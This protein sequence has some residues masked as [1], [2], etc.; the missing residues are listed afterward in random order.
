MKR[1]STVL[2]AALA[3]VEFSF[4]LNK[5]MSYTSLT[6]IPS[7]RPLFPNSTMPQQSVTDVSSLERETFHST[8]TDGPRFQPRSSTMA[9]HN[10]LSIILAAKKTHSLPA[11]S[12][13]GVSTS[14]MDVATRN[15]R[16]KSSEPEGAKSSSKAGPYMTT[17]SNQDS[18]SRRN[19]QSSGSLESTIRTPAR[20][21]AEPTSTSSLV[22]AFLH[23]TSST[24]EATSTFSALATRTKITIKLAQSSVTAAFDASFTQPYSVSFRGSTI[25]YTRATFS[26]LA[27]ITAATTITTPSWSPTTMTVNLL[28]LRVSSLLVLAEPGKCATSL[29]FARLWLPGSRFEGLKCPSL[30]AASQEHRKPDVSFSIPHH[31]DMIARWNGGIGGLNL[32]G[33]PCMWPFCPQR[34]HDDKSGNDQSDDEDE[35]EQ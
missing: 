35:G 12:P 30:L 21:S 6:T 25:Y 8:S 20:K 4:G 19:W 26:D 5:S 22:W 10:W 23:K 32:H 28:Q 31:A 34:S 33:P 15:Q 2:V 3:S 1:Y 13:N 7:W 11:F 27:S 24:E 9:S 18:S 17:A 16:S 29:L 14:D